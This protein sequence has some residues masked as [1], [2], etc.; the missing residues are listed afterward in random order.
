MLQRLFFTSYTLAKIIISPF[1]EKCGHEITER[2]STFL[3]SGTS[4]SLTLGVQRQSFLRQ[5]LTS[6]TV[7]VVFDDGDII[8]NHGF[9]IFAGVAWPVG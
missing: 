8:Q 1:S 5:R 7:G 9:A 2:R 6:L 4:I 3:K